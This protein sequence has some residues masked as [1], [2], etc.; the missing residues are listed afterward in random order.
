VYPLE[1]AL[2]RGVLFCGVG[3]RALIFG[4]SLVVGVEVGEE[5]WGTGF[6]GVV[7]FLDWETLLVPFV[8][9]SEALTGKIGCCFPGKAGGGTT[10]TERVVETRRRVI[11][12]LHLNRVPEII[13]LLPLTLIRRRTT[14]LDAFRVPLGGDFEVDVGVVSFFETL[15]CLLLAFSST[16]PSLTGEAK[17]SGS[18][19]SR[20]GVGANGSSSTPK[21]EVVGRTIC[22]V[23]PL[24][25]GTVALTCCCEDGEAYTGWSFE[26]S[27]SGTCCC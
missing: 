24:R 20:E 16:I 11:I 17:K 3:G 26:V 5:V 7:S 2:G 1:V 27:Y 10:V 22:E 12:I 23:A 6:F 13:L 14:A 21:A 19:F 25:E 15:S 9:T 8:L 18:G 4:M